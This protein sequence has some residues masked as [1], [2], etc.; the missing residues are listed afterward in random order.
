[1]GPPALAASAL[2]SSSPSSSLLDSALDQIIL[3]TH[4]LHLPSGLLAHNYDCTTRAHPSP[5]P[6]GGMY[7]ARAWGVGNGWVCAGI[8]RVF[9]NISAHIDS[10]HWVRDWLNTDATGPRRIDRVHTILLDLLDACLAY[11]R[12][13]GLFHNVI[14][15]NTTFVE[16]NLAQMLAATLYRLLE[17]HRAGT[18]GLPPLEGVQKERYERAAGAMCVAARRK[19]DRYGFVRDVC[20]SPRF[21][22]PGTAAEGQAWGVLMEVA[23]GD[24]EGKKAGLGLGSGMGY[25]PVCQ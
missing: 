18:L 15:D 1:M 4:Y 20:G 21:N 22:V 12:A 17:L 2:S 11:Q 24:W 6:N 8:V 19:V 9:R 14:D 23:R 13:D 7:G 10:V 25:I 5:S 16:A 3:M